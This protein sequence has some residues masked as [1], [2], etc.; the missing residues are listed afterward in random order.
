MNESAKCLLSYRAPST[1]SPF[2][3]RQQGI[4]GLQ[5][6]SLAVALLCSSPMDQAVPPQEVKEQ[7]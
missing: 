4:D 1:Y 3:S 6:W 2:S 7:E 5:G